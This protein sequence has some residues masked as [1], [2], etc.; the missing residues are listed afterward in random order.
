MGAPYSQD[1][2]GRVLTG[3]EPDRNGVFQD[4]AG[5]AEFGLSDKESTLEGD[6][7][8]ARPDHAERCEH[9]LQTLQMLTTE[10]ARLL[11]FRACD[12]D[13]SSKYS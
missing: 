13:Q 3:L 5:V 12:Q 9:R 4:Q 7:K 6:A 11:E 10:R 8:R 2:R 1:L